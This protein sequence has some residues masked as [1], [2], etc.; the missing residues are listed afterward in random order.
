MTRPTVRHTSRAGS[1]R[2][3]KIHALLVDHR[4]KWLRNSNTPLWNYKSIGIELET[5]WTNIRDDIRHMRDQLG[6]PI[7][8]VPK[9]HGHMYLQ[10]FTPVSTELLT[11]GDLT[12]LCFMMRAMEPFRQNPEY[13]KRIRTA[14][15]K[16]S[17]TLREELGISFRD[18]EK[19]V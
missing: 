2:I 18:L 6:Y 9:K 19:A 14:I 11:P 13:R 8:F 1:I 17:A 3:P 15:T 12:T 10:D 4:R 7:V 16:I 5:S